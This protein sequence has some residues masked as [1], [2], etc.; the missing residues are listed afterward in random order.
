MSLS[1]VVGAGGTGRAL[2]R[3][4]AEEGERV[5]L[6]TRS[7]SGPRHPGIE[8]VAADATDADRL[9]RLTEGAL[10][11]YNCAMPAYDRWPTDWPPLAGAMLAAAERTGADYVM[12]GNTYAYG[13][14]SGPITEDLP[15]APTTVKGRVRAQLW[16]DAL[17]AHQAGRVRVTDVRACDFL[18][19]DTLSVYNLV[20]LPHL[21]AGTPAA[22]PGDLDVEHSWTYIDD[23]ARTMIAAARHDAAWGNVWHVPSTSTLPV[24]ALTARLAALAGA[25]GPQLTAM[26]L[27][28][29]VRVGERD[30][31]MAELVEMQYL[32]REPH[33]LDSAHTEAVLGVTATPLDEVL[34]E[35]IDA[36]P[37]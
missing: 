26:P 28:E 37:A 22:Y 2:A 32:D 15:S 1:V 30:S 13:P 14:V 6:V 16:A 29:L 11:L 4:L 36:L 23:A 3:L 35:T 19:V 17:E 5:R 20:V 24:R 27:E 12:L 9:G 7:G 8:P 25:P 31:I 18:G 10:T 21:L 34:K 33:V